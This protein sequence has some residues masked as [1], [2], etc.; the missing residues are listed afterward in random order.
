MSSNKEQALKVLRQLIESIEALPEG[1]F[2][3]YPDAEVRKLT[4]PLN[5]GSGRMAY[6]ACGTLI[7]CSL[8]YLVGEISDS[9]FIA[10]IGPPRDWDT[11]VEPINDTGLVAEKRSL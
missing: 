1:E 9:D 8:K 2:L 7:S 11:E 3:A 6:S 4:K 5:D 10:K